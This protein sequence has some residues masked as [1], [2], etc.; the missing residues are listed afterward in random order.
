MGYLAGTDVQRLAV[1]A[2]GISKQEVRR[3]Q[4]PLPKELLVCL[5]RAIS[6]YQHD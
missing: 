6:H 1:D 5:L 3:R 4:F 2:L